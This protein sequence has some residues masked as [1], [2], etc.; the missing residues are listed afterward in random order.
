MSKMTEG[1][2]LAEITCTLL[3]NLVKL[4]NLSSAVASPA[5]DTARSSAVRAVLR[6]A[7]DLPVACHF[8][9]L[10][11]FGSLPHGWFGGLGVVSSTISLWEMWPTITVGVPSTTAVKKA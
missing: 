10:G 7:C 1:S 2:W 9:K 3:E 5:V 6:N 11:P 4:H 8:L